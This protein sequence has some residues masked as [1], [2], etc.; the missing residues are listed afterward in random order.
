M[1]NKKFSFYTTMSVQDAL[2][3]LQASAS[4]LTQAD[5]EKRLQEYGLNEIKEVDITWWQI[6]KTQILS[7]FM[8]VFFV[9]GLAY[10]LTGQLAECAIVLIIIVINVGIGFF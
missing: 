9:I 6:F 8:C 7:P 1:E 4:G 2:A 10:L 3:D 5:A